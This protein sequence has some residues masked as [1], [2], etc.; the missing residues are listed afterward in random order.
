[1]YTDERE[2][3]ETCSFCGYTSIFV[4]GGACPLCRM[5]GRLAASELAHG[6]RVM[7]LEYI[8][9]RLDD[10]YDCLQDAEQEKCA[11]CRKGGWS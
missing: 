1:M 10:A 7:C 11:Y 4:S 5:E 2:P 9:E 8:L 6:F 3:G